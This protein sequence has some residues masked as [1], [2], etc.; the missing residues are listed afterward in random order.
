[1]APMATPCTSPYEALPSVHTE[2][3]MVDGAS[4]NWKWPA[5]STSSCPTAPAATSE[6]DWVRTSRD[7]ET[8]HFNTSSACTPSE[9]NTPCW[10]GSLGDLGHW[11]TGRG[12]RWVQGEHLP[13]GRG[14]SVVEVFVVG[15]RRCAV[16]SSPR[17]HHRDG[18]RRAP[19]RHP[20]VVRRRRR[21]GARV[22]VL[23]E[24]RELDRTLAA[25]AAA[26]WRRQSVGPRSRLR[27]VDGYAPGSHR[28]RGELPG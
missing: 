7:C 18:H 22:P 4:T 19:P 25:S 15:F 24:P 28:R 26:C 10:N 5:S 14:S 8:E 23:V 16:P 9:R 20:Q 17:A 6:A 3:W 12:R 1:M 27:G 21:C 13:L 2:R 11:G